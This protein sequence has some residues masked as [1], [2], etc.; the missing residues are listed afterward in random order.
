MDVARRDECIAVAKKV[1]DKVRKGYAPAVRGGRSA[2]SVTRRSVSVVTPSAR[3]HAPVVW[4]MRTGSSAF[5]I[6]VGEDRCWVG[7]QSGDVYA[8]AHDGEVLAH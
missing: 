7:N 4:R 6:H 5:G 2:R 8:L 1:A 3:R